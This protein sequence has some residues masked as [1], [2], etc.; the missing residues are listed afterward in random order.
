M[1]AAIL[2][3]SPSDFPV[4]SPIAILAAESV[5][6]SPP[7]AQTRSHHTRS[8]AVSSDEEEEEKVQVAV[9]LKSLVSR[10]KE[11]S[12]RRESFG[13]V[14]RRGLGGLESVLEDSE[15][16]E[17]DGARQEVGDGLQAPVSPSSR[18]RIFRRN[19]PTV[20]AR[21]TSLKS[22]VRVASSERRNS[23]PLTPPKSPMDV[24]AFGLPASL[25][26][27]TINTKIVPCVFPSSYSSSSLSS[28][29]DESDSSSSADEACTT[30][31]SCSSFGYQQ[32][33]FPS[34]DTT[35]F[36]QPI[37][38]KPQQLKTVLPGSQN[39]S[40]GAVVAPSV[41]SGISSRSCLTLPKNDY[42]LKAGRRQQIDL[43]LPS[44]GARKLAQ[45]PSPV[46]Q[47]QQ[48]QQRQ[49]SGRRVSAPLPTLSQIS[50]RLQP[51]RRSTA[52][53]AVQTVNTNAGAVE[54]G[55]RLPPFLLARRLR[56]EAA[57]IAA[58]VVIIEEP[59]EIGSEAG[60]AVG[61][62][63]PIKTIASFSIPTFTV[64]P[65]PE[66]AEEGRKV[67]QLL[68]GRLSARF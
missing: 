54:A 8:A 44:I 29:S 9:G 7:L 37:Q 52:P 58:S 38:S 42:A 10:A 26:S 56:E 63:A 31:T 39:V 6:L 35:Y 21:L 20:V 47:Q 50:A 51:I 55:S 30:P 53:A 57:K 24:N 19:S 23:L 22:N 11:R 67:R 48:Q 16:E 25:T 62:P 27:Q 34:E 49:S 17:E 61:E 64:T 32:S 60:E 13:P 41:G 65:P 40:R 1:S 2:I 45:V 46:P 36:D 4:E 18:P 3:L 43:I 14:E 68:V 28:S 15:T 5:L 66:R 59:L 12:K 33:L